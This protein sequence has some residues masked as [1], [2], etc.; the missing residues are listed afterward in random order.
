MVQ[1]FYRQGR[2]DE[3]NDVVEYDRLWTLNRQAANDTK[4]FQIRFI[5]KY[6]IFSKS[7]YRPETSRQCRFVTPATMNVYPSMME[8]LS[9][10]TFQMI[11]PF[12]FQT[13]EYHQFVRR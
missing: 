3:R 6:V 12:T 7:R 5:W 11:C 9:S 4:W 1:M 13:D 10:P 8:V 2:D